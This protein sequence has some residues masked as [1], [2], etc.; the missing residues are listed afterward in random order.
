MARSHLTAR[1]LAPPPRCASTS[2]CWH[3]LGRSTGTDG[4]RRR[5]LWG[6]RRSPCRA[7]ASAWGHCSV[8]CYSTPKEGRC[9]ERKP[10]IQDSPSCMLGLHVT[11]TLSRSC[12]LARN[13]WWPVGWIP[14]PEGIHALPSLS[15]PQ[16]RLG[17]VGRF[18][19]RSLQSA[20][21]ARPERRSA[22]RPY[23][24]T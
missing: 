23:H 1:I 18:A 15:Q 9:P 6:R 7:A 24:P 2:G 5:R 12:G 17:I 16:T 10:H 20:E 22:E 8:K 4:S 13:I 14:A 11:H 21:V 19:G 3:G